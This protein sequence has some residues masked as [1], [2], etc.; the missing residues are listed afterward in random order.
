MAQL[1][2]ELDEKCQSILVT[3][4]VDSQ[5]L[6][7]Q[8]ELLFGDD[9]NAF[10]DLHPEA[11]EETSGLDWEKPHGIVHESS[12]VYLPWPADHASFLN[13]AD[14][15]KNLCLEIAS[16]SAPHHRSAW[17]NDKGQLYS[18]ED[19]TTIQLQTKT[20]SVVT[21]SLHNRPVEGLHKNEVNTSNGSSTGGPVL[22]PGSLRE[23]GE[24]CIMHFT[25]SESMTMTKT[26]SAPQ[27]T[28][29]VDKVDFYNVN[30]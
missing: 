10:D 9:E 22:F 18:S 29:Q 7:Q 1:R 19:V 5:S 3:H 20:S 23:R 15:K 27:F 28:W 14:T 30:D 8:E 6:L 24:F 21:K 2:P 13:A 11:K 4:Y 26:Y 16:G 17:I 25:L 12:G